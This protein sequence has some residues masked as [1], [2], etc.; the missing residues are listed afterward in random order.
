MFITWEEAKQKYPDK[1]V[2]FRNPQYKDIF[3][4][5]FIGGEF[6]M[7]ANNQ[8]ELFSSIPEG[9]GKFTSRHTR[10]DDAVGVGLA[11]LFGRVSCAMKLAHLKHFEYTPRQRVQV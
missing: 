3:H 8:K 2:V 7:T 5:E 1:W 10:E 11:K 6:V 4:M 9:I